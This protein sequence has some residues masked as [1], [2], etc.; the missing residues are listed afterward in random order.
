M[1]IPVTVFSVLILVSVASA[2]LTPVLLMV[3]FLL[4]LKKGKTW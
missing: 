1:T 4:D 3:L 2:A